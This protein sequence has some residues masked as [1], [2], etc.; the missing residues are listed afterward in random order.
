MEEQ[1]GRWRKKVEVENYFCAARGAAQCWRRCADL[2]E[3]ITRFDDGGTISELRQQ[4]RQ[5]PSCLCGSLIAKRCC[6][7]TCIF[8]GRLSNNRRVRNL[9][10]R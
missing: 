7:S 10:P 3:V 8:R 6:L 9:D 2:D 4:K 1:D 5:Q